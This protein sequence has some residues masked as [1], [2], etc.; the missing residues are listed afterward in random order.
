MIR[1]IPVP[2]DVP[3]DMEIIIM[4]FAQSDS[5]GNT[6]A[7]CKASASIITALTGKPVAA[8]MKIIKQLTG[9]IEF[10]LLEYSST[11]PGT[12]V[13]VTNSADGKKCN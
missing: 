5:S 9:A 2:D 13:T 7:C 4:V 10:M 6:Q 11:I 1:Q 12:D 8:K 3:Q